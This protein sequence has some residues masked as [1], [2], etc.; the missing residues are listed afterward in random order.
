MKKRFIL[1]IF[2]LFCA[3]YNGNAKSPEELFNKGSE[4]YI[5]G[6]LQKAVNIWEKAYIK[7]KESKK[8]KDV[9]IN[10]LVI[11]GKFDLKDK[12]FIRA[13]KYLEQADELESSKKIKTLI[14]FTEMEE[15]FHVGEDM[16]PAEQLVTDEEESAIMSLIFVSEE[17]EDNKNTAATKEKE[18][19]KDE[20]VTEGAGKIIVK[21]RPTSIRM[22]SIK[23]TTEEFFYLSATLTDELNKNRLVNKELI[24]KFESTTKTVRTDN[25]GKA[26]VRFF[27]RHEPG[28][29]YLSASF[30]S[31]PTFMKT[32][33]RSKF[34]IIKREVILK[35][36][37]AKE[38]ARNEFPV[39]ATLLDAKT[40]T[41]IPDQN[42]VFIFQKNIKKE[43][44]GTDGTATVMFK[45]PLDIG[46]H[47]Y[48]VSFPGS[49][50][51]SP[52]SE[53]KGKITVLKR[54]S[55]LAV[56]NTTVSCKGNFILMA[57]L[58][59]S[60]TDEPVRNGKIKFTFRGEE[61][62]S[63]T[64]NMGKAEANFNAPEK[65]AVDSASVLFLGSDIYN[66]AGTRSKVN[67][68][69]REV[70]LIKENVSTMA[71][72]NFILRA[73]LKDKET[74][75]PIPDRTIS[76]F[77]SG[78]PQ[79]I[80]T[81]A[82]GIAEAAFIAPRESGAY[83]YTVSFAGDETYAS[84][85]GFAKG[86]KTYTVKYGDNLSII[87]LKFYGDSSKWKVI[88]DKNPQIGAPTLIRPGMQLIIP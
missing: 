62:E 45:A 48:S 60:D 67:T 86:M 82:S 53:N 66:R 35:V 7:D 83:D 24:F 63:I 8:Y 57:T 49:S 77:F 20:P 73:T 78:K 76:I 87:A 13:K 37:N 85:G 75:Q 69:R 79:Q 15:M 71:K 65:I 19:E 21:K 2:I 17:I 26:K 25:Y 41:I 61:K 43:R 64:D 22:S 31:D 59:D 4:E 81:D 23:A 18:I 80:K 36:S 5:N 39:K 30:N 34:E 46:I 55:R 54:N 47:E 32:T 88:F 14:T 70:L 28:D 58:R 12:D 56:K 51:H 42:L 84:A 50:K 1:G 40:R 9:L 6:N 38:K 3:V 27:A 11:L 52:S 44:T 33:T 29:Y 68:E 16:I 74:S 72:E 10:G